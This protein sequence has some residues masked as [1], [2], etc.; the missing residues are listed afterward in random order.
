MEPERRRRLER[1]L[2][3][4]DPDRRLEWLDALDPESAA[5]LRRGGGRQRVLRALEV[6]LLTGRPL[7]WW[8]RERPGREPGLDA[9]VFVLDRPRGSLDRRIDAR[10]DAMFRAGLVDEVAG[11]LEAGYRSDD[12]G[13]SATGYPEV[14]AA[15]R[16]DL[17]LDQA[18]E[19]IRRLTRRYARRQ[20]TWFR[21]QLP[22]DAIW[23]DGTR[24]MDELVEEA[25]ETWRNEA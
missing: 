13:L 24:P 9:L 3:D 19:R 5:R 12:P 18:A 10:V 22:I 16:G 7:G 6:A 4:R 23:L 25:V 20:M 8:H 21:N 14:I 15:L 17:S 2:S 11:L 1:A